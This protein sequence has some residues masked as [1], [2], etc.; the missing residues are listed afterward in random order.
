M[1]RQHHLFIACVAISVLL[2][3]CRHQG[4]ALDPKISYAPPAQR[5]ERLEEPFVQLTEQEYAQ[6][7]G[8]ELFMGKAF[9]HE[10]DLYRALSCFKRS[11]LLIPKDNVSRLLEIEYDIFLAYYLAQ[12]YGDAVDVFE[13]G[14][15]LQAPGDFEALPTLILL[16]YDAYLQLDRTEKALRL[17]DL[18]SSMEI[19][20]A[21]ELILANAIVHADFASMN[22]ILAI[23]EGQC[24]SPLPPI[25]Q[26]K[27]GTIHG[28]IA[29]YQLEK[30]SVS[31]AR[32]LNAVL[33]GAGYLYVGQPKT[34]LTSLIINGLFAAAAYQ[35]FDHGYLPAALIVTSLEMGWY[36]GGINGAGLAASSY[37]NALY[38]NRAKD[39]LLQNRLFPILMVEQGF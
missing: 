33:P 6:D 36:F 35:L 19:A 39:A 26:E 37:N 7:W 16:L 22:Q 4:D 5:I 12:K 17:L 11:R 27:Q 24:E 38:Q 29:G 34:A 28:F 18:I 30:K 15:L 20:S 10:M 13:R 21:S 25:S 8:K 3:S 14:P 1:M 9:A 31:K 32:M 23:A 2:T